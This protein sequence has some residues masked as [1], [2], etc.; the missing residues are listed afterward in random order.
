MRDVVIVSAARTPVGSFGGSLK[1]LGAVKLG[2]IAVSAALER[3]K[4]K[5]A[6]VEEVVLGCV[7]QA[8]QGQN[9]ARQIAMGSGIPKEVP[10]MTINKVCASGLRSVSLA[11][12]II[13]AGDADIV[14]AGG[15]E[16]MTDTPFA[17]M[18]A[19]WGYRMG[20]NKLV[21]VMIK[22]GLWDIFNNYHMGITAENVAEQW[23]LTRGEQDAF[24]LQS[25]NRAEKAIKEGRFADE[26]IPVTIPQKK[27][28]PKVFD[29]DEFPRFGTTA[30]GLSGL[31]PAFKKDGTVTAGNAS[32]INDGAA[33][34]VVMSAE[35][36]KAMGA[37]PLAKIVS[38]A[39]AGVDPSIMGTGPIPATR[40][41]LEKAGMKITD[42]DLV[43]ANEAFAS[44]SLAVA[45]ELG[46]D[47]MM[48]KVN[49]NGGAIALGHP[50]GASGGRILTTLLYEMKK[51]GSKYGLATL[52][53]GGGQGAAMIVE[54]LS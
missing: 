24:G 49:V 4:V 54:M 25:Q 52:C 12:Q 22:D 45:K 53:I 13:K 51:R 34:F 42:M 38:Y 46:L 47:K 27:G 39:S 43:E 20:E 29:T 30:E 1:G 8:A 7:L 11:A 21:D 28:D 41:A 15:T 5:P 31:K 48:D 10:A 35:K 23:K 19:R 50:I 16:N 40:K 18:D 36:A 33:A 14:I 26:I 17:L 3:A 44:Q 2:V 37:K 6:D 9:V 32:G